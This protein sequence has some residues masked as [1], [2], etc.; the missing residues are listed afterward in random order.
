MSDILL[1]VIELLCVELW[2]EIF[3]YFN[4]HDLWYSFRGLNSR[5]DAIMDQ[6]IL[7]IDFKNGDDYSYFEKNILLSVKNIANVRSLKLRRTNEIKHFFLIYSLSSFTQLRL[8]SLTLK[9][10]FNDK[11]FRFWNQLSSLKNLRRL[12]IKFWGITG[13]NNCIQEKEYIIRSI[14]NKDYCPLLESLI[15]STCGRQKQIPTIP[16]L[17]RTSRSTNLKRLFIDS[18]TFN[19]LIKLFPALA[20]LQT[21]CIDYKLYADDQPDPREP[22]I[23]TTGLMLPKCI[24]LNLRSVNVIMFEQIEYLLQQTPNLK[25]LFLSGWYHIP[26]AKKWELLLSIQCPKLIKFYLSCRGGAYNADFYQA[27]D[28]FAE[29]CNITPYWLTR[30]TITEMYGYFRCRFE[31]Y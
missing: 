7:H 4:F 1:S 6:I 3:E 23:L 12:E 24:Q 8:L 2:Q 31:Y 27:I 18:L 28:D 22:Q 15:I 5:I 29:E 9:Y 25:E 14:F 19:D 30:H 17:I 26:N 10:S 11:L 20:N 21:C 13:P 16:L